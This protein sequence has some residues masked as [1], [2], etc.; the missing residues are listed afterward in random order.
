MNLILLVGNGINNIRRTYRWQDLIQQLIEYIGASG[1]IRVENKPFPLLYE[2]I[3]V[4]AVKNRGIREKDIKSFIA[5]E[6]GRLQPNEVH[7]QIFDLK[8]SHLLTTNYDFTL[9]R[10]L[11]EKTNTL[12]NQGVVKE[13]TYSLFRRHVL[14][15][16][17]F[18]HIHGD[19]NS[20]NSLALGYEHYSGYL[21]Q[22]RNYLAVGTRNTYKIR[23]EPLER[24][25]RKKELE[26]DSW[27]DAFFQKNT[28]VC[29]VGLTLDFIEIHLWWLLTYRQRL[30]LREKLH[31]RGRIYYFYPDTLT[32]AIQ[33]KLDLLKSL[34]VLP[35]SVKH[36]DKQPALFYHT[37][38]KKIKNDLK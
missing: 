19:A 14:E 25:L 15:K 5:R 32:P 11:T 13:N 28:H 26:M 22:M 37:V 1:Q 17:T 21:Q 38:L 23:F 2:E 36:T 7:E 30:I 27:V 12:G 29:I 24:R 18:W 3:I 4:E 9:E 20:R 35:F 10:V 8:W 6:I 34:G 31:T 16:R 33:P